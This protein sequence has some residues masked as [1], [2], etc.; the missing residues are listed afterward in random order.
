[1]PRPVVY[2]G[3]HA[4]VGT[5]YKVQYIGTAPSGAGDDD[6]SWTVYKFTWDV[7]PDNSVA[8]VEAQELNGVAWSNRA[9]LPW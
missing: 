4:L 5:K 7:M 3:E 8:L 9:S 2:K 6:L 1:M